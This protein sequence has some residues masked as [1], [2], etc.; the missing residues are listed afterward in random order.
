MEASDIHGECKLCLQAVSTANLELAEYGNC[1][2]DLVNDYN[3]VID[4]FRELNSFVADAVRAVSAED[5]IQDQTAKAE[6][7]R[8]IKSADAGQ[9]GKVPPW[10]TD[11]A[12]RAAVRLFAQDQVTAERAYQYCKN[13][14]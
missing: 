9:E 12:L 11:I 2:L 7:V 14:I 4:H 3:A 5:G 1:F 8:T 10:T 13:K 6:Y